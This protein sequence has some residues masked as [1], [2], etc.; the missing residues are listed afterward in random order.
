MEKQG[1]G[2]GEKCPAPQC[3]ISWYFV[4]LINIFFSIRTLEVNRRGEMAQR[5][6]F[7]ADPRRHLRGG[8]FEP[9]HPAGSSE[10]GSVL[11]GEPRPRRRHRGA[12]ATRVSHLYKEM[13]TVQVL[14]LGAHHFMSGGF[15]DRSRHS[16]A[17]HAVLRGGDPIR[18]RLARHLLWPRLPPLLRESGG[19]GS[20]LN[21]RPYPRSTQ[22]WP[23]PAARLSSPPSPP[24]YP[25]L[26]PATRCQ[27]RG[28]R[29]RGS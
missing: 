2:G 23:P 14:F 1:G 16:R 21:D 12:S 28:P 20:A 5:Q 8:D 25:R 6:G 10:G 26:E 3:A 11:D 4:V 13:L 24:R 9:G 29:S 18:E 22:A 27:A 15:A 7:G 19:D 17:C